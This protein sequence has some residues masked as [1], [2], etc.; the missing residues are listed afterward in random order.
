MK[1]LNLLSP[2]IILLKLVVKIKLERCKSCGKNVRFS[3][4]SHLYHPECIRI[5]SNV[6][7]GHNCYIEAH[8]LYLGKE[9]GY[10]P[11]LVIGNNVT[12][13]DNS[14]VT[15]LNEIIIGDGLLTG[16]NVY[17]GDNS[18]GE[19]NNL[20]GNVIPPF[21]KAL[22]SKGPI[23]IG[24]NVWIGRNACILGGVTIGDNV[25]IGA[26]SVVTH[27]IPSNSVAA[28]APAKIIRT[29]K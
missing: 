6:S 2:R 10:K 5:G 26:N 12:I 23:H 9:T 20:K 28:G 7:V 15:C 29:E 11:N 21:E 1:I 18:H 24:K 19:T 8:P 3:Y 16:P 14:M 25:I 4:S 13:T 17:I 27:D 22:Y